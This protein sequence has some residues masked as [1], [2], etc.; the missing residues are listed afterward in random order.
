MADRRGSVLLRI[1]H[2]PAIYGDEHT[3]VRRRERR[4]GKRREF[5][6]EHHATDGHQLR[7]C[8]GVAGDRFIP[9]RHTSSAPQ[10]IHGV[11]RAFFVLGGMTILST[12]VF[13]ELNKDD[14]EA[15]SQKESSHA[16]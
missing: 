11:H 16:A 13:R 10:F 6:R 12:I 4:T 8:F 2:V 5:H 9:D 1:L 7:R 3:G 14:G 15:V